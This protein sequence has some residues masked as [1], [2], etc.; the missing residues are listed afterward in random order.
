[1]KSNSFSILFVGLLSIILFSCAA[2]L[3]G[4]LSS[5][6]MALIRVAG[7]RATAAGVAIESNAAVL[8]QLSRVRIMRAASGRQLYIMENG[9]RRVFADLVKSNSIRWVESG[10]VQGLPGHLYAVRSSI[11][12]ANIRLG[13]GKHF[14]IYKTVNADELLIVLEERDG[15]FKLLLEE[16][17]EGW[18]FAG[19]VTAAFE[20]GNSLTAPASSFSQQMG[21]Q[22]LQNMPDNSTVFKTLNC[23][24]CSGDGQADCYS[25]G[26]NGLLYC[27]GC[28]GS[29]KS[30]CIMCKGGGQKECV[31]SSA[32]G[33]SSCLECFA[34]GYRLCSRC[35]GNG[36]IIYEGRWITCPGCNGAKQLDCGNCVKGLANCRYC[37]GDG[38]S[39]CNYCNGTGQG[40]MTCMTCYGKPAIYCTECN[41]NKTTRCFDCLGNGR[42]SL[43]VNP[44]KRGYNCQTT[45]IGGIYLVNNYCG[46]VQF[47]IYEQSY[48][49]VEVYSSAIAAKETITFSNFSRGTYRVDAVYDGRVISSKMFE[50]SPCGEQFVFLG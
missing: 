27:I 50:V 40:S 35:F 34:N 45:Q 31:F 48:G 19:L 30:A 37:A 39:F 12:R 17:V 9:K 41:G 5:S 46:A 23:T 47:R 16:G 44:I 36:E 1:M 21:G 32:S 8:S 20:D 13:P 43:Q 11:G 4:A 28:R 29:G 49:L 26:G 3:V 6:E 7:V 25:C 10:T 22:W 38:Q 42:L 14:K 2:R 18:M 24:T 33:K 15:W